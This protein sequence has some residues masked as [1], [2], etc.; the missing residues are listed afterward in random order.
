MTRFIGLPLCDSFINFNQ[1]GYIYGWEWSQH[2]PELIQ[3]YSAKMKIKIK[4]EVMCYHML[5]GYKFNHETQMCGSP[6]VVGQLSTVV[7]QL[8]Y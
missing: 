7:I 3:M 2:E 8:I 4:S 6:K 5:R 1:E